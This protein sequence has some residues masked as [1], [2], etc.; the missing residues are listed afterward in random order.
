MS[1]IDGIYISEDHKHT[2]TIIDSTT[3]PA[4]A[5]GGSF[6][7]NSLST[8]RVN[9]TQIIGQFK[10]PSDNPAK[11]WPSQISFYSYFISSPRTY[12][13]AD[14]W[15]GIRMADGNIIMSGLRTYTTD[16]GLYDMHYFE[17]I[18]LTLAPTET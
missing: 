13:I 16:A 6:I 1:L 10:Y 17:K 4:G 12:V 18:F 2:L 7:S 3:S 15:N 9:Y 11:I 5:F 14:H 8:G